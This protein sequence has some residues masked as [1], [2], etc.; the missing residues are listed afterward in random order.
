MHTKWFKNCKTEEEREKR[1]QELLSY[2][3]AFEELSILLK[4]QFEEA[5]PDYDNPSWSHAQADVNGA[6]RKLKQILNLLEIK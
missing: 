4:E 1:K 3:N 6:N 5:A 2:R